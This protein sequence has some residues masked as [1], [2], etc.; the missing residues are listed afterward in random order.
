M[1]Y[2]DHCIVTCLLKMQ[3]LG[4]IQAERVFRAFQEISISDLKEELHEAVFS[5]SIDNSAEEQSCDGK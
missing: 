3:R 2:G 1:K 5:Q 4:K